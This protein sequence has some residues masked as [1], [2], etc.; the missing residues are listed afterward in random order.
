MESTGKKLGFTN[1]KGHKIIT[2]C[3]GMG[4]NSSSIAAKKAQSVPKKPKT[5]IFEAKAVIPSTIFKKCYD[6]GDLPIV[7]DFIGAHRK[8]AWKVEVDLL[9]Y[10]HYLPIFFHGL[11]ETEDPYKFLADQGLNALIQFGK[12]KIL[13][14]LPQL[15]IP[16]KEALST[17]N[18]EIV[19]KTLRKLQALVKVSEAVAESLVPYY[20]Q[21]L[22]IFN[23]L[24]HRNTNLGDK[25]DYGQRKGDNVGDLIQ[26]TLEQFEKHG[27]EDAYINIKYMIPTYESCM[28]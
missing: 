28:F 18:H 8:I 1:V 12:E 21:I 10:H 17:K 23:L 11:R 26:E 7:V 22:P 13:P 15:I 4:G 3:A 2:K 5:G 19:V 16:I 25:I 14:V 6:R 27:G 9:D 24:R 20:R